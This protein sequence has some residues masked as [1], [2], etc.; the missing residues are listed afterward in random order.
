MGKKT[1][2]L[3]VFLALA[4]ILSYV[5]VLIP[6]QLGIPGA[7]LGLANLIVVVMLYEMGAKEAA[8]VAVLRIVLSGFLFGNLFSIVYSLAGGL[9]SFVIMYLLKKSRLFHTVTVSVM[10]GISHNIGQVLIAAY[11]A[12]N[13]HV[14]YY[15][16]VL[17]FAGF[18]TGLLIGLIAVRLC[19]R[20]SRLF[21]D[22]APREL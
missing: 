1:A 2:Y 5:E 14:L 21:T 19:G 22:N 6:F 7:K 16:P 20:L 13:I 11:L 10:G 8:V 18:V 3:G 4:L 9:L 17:V 12:G 15:T